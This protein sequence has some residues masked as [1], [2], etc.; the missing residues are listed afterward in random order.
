[1]SYPID[2][3]NGLHIKSNTNNLPT[4]N[5]PKGMK[6]V[7][8]EYNGTTVEVPEPYYNQLKE[9][10][11]K[12]FGTGN[13]KKGFT[14]TVVE[15]RDN[16]QVYDITYT[17]PLVLAMIEGL[18]RYEKDN[19]LY[20]VSLSDFPIVVGDILNKVEFPENVKLVLTQISDPR[21]TQGRSNLSMGLHVEIT[22]KIKGEHN[23]TK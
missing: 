20:E 18:T 10:V 11:I 9:E 16:I 8:A 14:D 23:D 19:Y 12:L 1:M 5:I 15:H 17:V 13:A 7:K 4:L 3:L 6:T 21:Y 2:I 22:E